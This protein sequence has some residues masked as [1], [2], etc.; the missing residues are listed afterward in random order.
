MRGLAVSH[1]LDAGRARNR[2]DGG[3][4]TLILCVLAHRPGVAACGIGGR[5]R[6][7]SVIVAGERLPAAWDRHGIG[8]T[9]MM[10]RRADHI[11]VHREQHGREGD[12]P[13]CDVL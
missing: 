9:P 12:G 2:A 8:A 7:F 5:R 11:P 3:L 1:G 10:T 4:A 13:S 6:G